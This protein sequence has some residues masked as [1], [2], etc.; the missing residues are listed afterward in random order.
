VGKVPSDNATPVFNY[1]GIRRV[2]GVWAKFH[3]FLTPTLDEDKVRL[4]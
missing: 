3:A 4:S 1:C 2:G